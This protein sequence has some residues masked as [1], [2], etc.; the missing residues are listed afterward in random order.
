MIKPVYIR[1]SD[2]LI[3]NNP[4]TDYEILES[5]NKCITDIKCIQRDRGLW[6]IYVN[7]PES[8]TILLAEGF[9]FRNTSV[10]AFETNPFSAG[11]SSPLEEVLKI[12]IK[13]VPLSVDDGEILKMLE[14]FEVSLTSPI[15]YENIRNPTTRK[16]TSILNGNR[17]VYAKPLPNG[18]SLPRSSFC[19]GLKCLIYHKGQPSNK[20]KPLCTNCWGDHWSSQCTDSKRCRICLKDDHDPGSEKCESYVEN[21]DNV[22]SFAGPDNPLSNFYPCFLNVFGVN[23]HS[24]EHAFQYV[25]AIRCGDIQKAQAIQEA[26]TALDAKKLGKD[27]TN[28][29]EFISKRQE[30]MEEILNAKYSQV[31]D[32]RSA[33]KKGTPST[34]FAESVFDVF[35]GTGLNRTATDH[36][37]YR[38]WPGKNIM[39]KLLD[40]IAGENR[41]P[42]RSVSV[43]RNLQM[44]EQRNISDM[45][46]SIRKSDSKKPSEKRSP[47]RAQNSRSPKRT[48][49][50]NR[51]SNKNSKNSV[52][53]SINSPHKTD[54]G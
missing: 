35:W 19:A 23:H 13:G 15:R 33:V 39:G 2:I 7:T 26:E 43:P 1:N 30:I 46:N 5:V 28:T 29:D 34:I 12:T 50:N 36:T 49:R 45:L 9:D 3:G 22:T 21:Q 6:R 10:T 14:N 4:V 38:K 25:K 11:T 48:S 27:I 53:Q 44:S 40:K 31:D 8:R 42:R 32:F 16:M 17:F 52:D 37:D 47:N 51:K 41:P 54:C 24:S 20:R 18:K